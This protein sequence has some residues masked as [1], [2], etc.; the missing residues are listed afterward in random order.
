[1]SII[2]YDDRKYSKGERVR[3]F[4][5]PTDK[6]YFGMKS[7]STEDFCEAMFRV[8]GYA[9]IKISKKKINE[10]RKQ[11]FLDSIEL[12]SPRNTGRDIR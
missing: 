1:M 8:L 5:A 4:I 2:R 12:G 6:L 7:I 9:N 11:L 10:V 3:I